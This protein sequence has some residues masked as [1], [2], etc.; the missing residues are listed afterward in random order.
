MKNEIETVYELTRSAALV[1]FRIC[2][3]GEYPDVPGNAS[4]VTHR[5]DVSWSAIPDPGRALSLA[6]AGPAETPRTTIEKDESG[7]SATF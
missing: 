3:E 7:S 6:Y 5:Q 2:V 4:P 1:R